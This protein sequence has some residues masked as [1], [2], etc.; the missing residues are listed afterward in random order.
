M[1]LKAFS[2]TVRRKYGEAG[3]EVEYTE[4]NSLRSIY[5]AAR[6]SN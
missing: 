1:L 3:I 4:M 5:F 6:L 2:E